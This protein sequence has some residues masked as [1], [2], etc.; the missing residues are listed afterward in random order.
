MNVF[1][2]ERAFARKKKE[3]WPYLYW[4]IDLHD[5]VF[6]GHYTANQELQL[7]PGAEEVL[8]LLTDRED[9]KLIAY[10]SSH[11]I[12]FANIGRWLKVNHQIRFSYF[13]ENPECSSTSLASFEDKFYFNILLDDKAGFV[14][15]TDWLLIKEELI[16]IGEFK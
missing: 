13:N 4:A 10:S 15:E 2:I 3:N 11:Y 16:R 7:Y 1:N 14:G 9:M 8:A 12:D 6:K 5:T